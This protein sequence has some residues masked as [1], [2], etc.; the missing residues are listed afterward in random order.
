MFAG[1]GEAFS[2][3]EVEAIDLQAGLDHCDLVR[4]PEVRRVVAEFLGCG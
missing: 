3:L 4:S 2:D 1:W